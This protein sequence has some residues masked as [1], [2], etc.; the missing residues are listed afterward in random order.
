VHGHVPFAE[1]LVVTASSPCD[2]NP[3][4]PRHNSWLLSKTLARYS[5]SGLPNM[6]ITTVFIKNFR[7]IGDS[8]VS[9]S[10]DNFNLFI[11][12]NGTCKTAILEGL[13]LCLSPSY[14]ASRISIK[15]FHKGSDSPIEIR[16]TFEKPF[17]VSIPDL[18]GNNQKLKC[19]AIALSAKKRDRSAPGKAFND[20]VVAEHH[21][22]PVEPKGQEVCVPKTLSTLMR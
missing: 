2:C 7:G 13:N 16:V 4:N 18:F 19:N 3:G 1:S 11:G 14:A 10:C 22:V 15:D 12:D 21:Y 17:D 5:A 8:G 9:F 6:K 20:L